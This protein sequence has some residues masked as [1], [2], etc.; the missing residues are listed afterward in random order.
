M[1]TKITSPVL[2]NFVSKHPDLLRNF[3]I[4][5]LAVFI[6]GFILHLSGMKNTDNVLIFGSVL[7]ALTYF[8]FAFQIHESENLE[9]TGVLNSHAFINFIYKITYLSYFTLFI[10]AA[11][12]IL[13]KG[14][15]WAVIAAS[16][17]LL[18]SILIIS[19]ISKINDRSKIYNFAFYVRIVPFITLMIYLVHLVFIQK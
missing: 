2:T 16:G 14:S 5:S 3:E 4:I 7:T 18:F 9:T 15:S 1:V 10:G 11:A 12:L 17:I 19:L 8:L 13:Q 6:T